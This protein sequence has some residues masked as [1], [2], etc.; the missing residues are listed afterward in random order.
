M[1]KVYDGDESPSNLIKIL[2]G[3]LC[4]SSMLSAR[5]YVTMRFISDLVLQEAGFQIV[6]QGISILVFFKTFF[7]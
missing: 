4:P 3:F 2:S 7:R 1:F 5:N 6:Y